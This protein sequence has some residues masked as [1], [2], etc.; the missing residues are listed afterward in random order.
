M[1]STEV[2]LA[3]FDASAADF[4]F[5]DL[6]HVY[7]YAVD[8]RMRLYR[9]EERWALIVEAVGYNP[10]AGNLI[11][12][13]HV[14][15]NCLTVGE[16]GLLDEDFLQRLDNMDEVHDGEWNYAGI[17][18]IVRGRALEVAV[19]PGVR[20]WDACRALVPAH[21]DLLLADE[22]EL[23]ARIPADLPE[24]LRLEEW[25][26]PEDVCEEPPSESETYRQI[27]EVL[28]TGDPARYRPTLKPNTHWSNW[29]ES[30]W[31]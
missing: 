13:R 8:A 31:M 23:R 27:A 21:R 7:Y 22:A 10:R 26:Q 29:P 30:G 20:M 3:Q 2:I 24:L 4:D 15:G 14:Y 16:P 28:A 6:G 11:D 5:P 12:K 18:L 1:D 25:H 19:E 17:P 9:D